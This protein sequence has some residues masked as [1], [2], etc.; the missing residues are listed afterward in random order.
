MLTINSSIKA[1]PPIP[2][3]C[4]AGFLNPLLLSEVFHH[5]SQC[6]LRDYVPFV[7]LGIYAL[8][9]KI[10]NILKQFINNRNTALQRGTIYFSF[11]LLCARFTNIEL[12]VK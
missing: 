8:Q 10:Q 5:I 1:H 12:Q 4:T 2:S 9:I 11:I 6:V 7:G 3:F